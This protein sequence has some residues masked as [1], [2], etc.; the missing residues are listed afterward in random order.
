MRRWGEKEK[1]MKTPHFLDQSYFVGERVNF[2]RV[3]GAGLTTNSITT[4]LPW[5]CVPVRKG[6]NG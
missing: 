4:P 2:L 5:E 6:E 1:T 3:L